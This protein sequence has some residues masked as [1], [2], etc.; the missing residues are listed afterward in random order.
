MALPSSGPLTLNQIGSEL[1]VSSPYSLHNMSLQAGFNTTPDRISEFYSLNLPPW[2]SNRIVYLNAANPASYP[3]TGTTWYDTISGYNVTLTNPTFT[4]NGGYFTSNSS[5][6]FVLPGNSTIY[7]G[8]FTWCMRIK[9]T[10][11]F[12]DWMMLWWSESTYKNFGIGVYLSSTSLFTP[13]IDSQYSSYAYWNNASSGTGNNGASPKQSSGNLLA[14]TPWS[15]ITVV[16][17]GNIFTWYL[18]ADANPLW[19]ITIS[20]WSI[21]DT[22]QSINL[23]CI[24]QNNYFSRAVVNKMVMFNR[25]LSTS[26]ISAVNTL[27]NMAG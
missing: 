11:T 18:N 22:S 5:T 7:S 9:Y 10:S 3:G 27:T 16:K 2:P 20:D 19:Q 13:R 6:N 26:E 15:L 14:T 8:T 1:Q 21:A 24:S 17:N 25:A 23:M 4:Q 12:S